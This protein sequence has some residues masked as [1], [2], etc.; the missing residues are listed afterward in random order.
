MSQSISEKDSQISKQVDSSSKTVQ[1][2]SE[3]GTTTSDALTKA[4]TDA[5][6]EAQRLTFSDKESATYAQELAKNMVLN[7]HLRL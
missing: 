3:K 4:F 5:K 7:L 1:T 2:V 6:Q